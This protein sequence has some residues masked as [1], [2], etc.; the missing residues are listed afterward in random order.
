MRR[1]F[2]AMMLIC[3]AAPA[4][5]LSGDESAALTK[6]E[7]YLNGI[8]TLQARFVQVN[9][10]GTSYEGDLFLSRPGKMR[11][12]YDPPT[13]M[14]L[15]AD[16]VFLISVDTQMKDATRIDLNDTPAGLLLKENLSFSDP[17]V[18]LRGV[19]MGANTIEITAAMAKDPTA[20]Q[21]TMV[22][23][24]SPLELKQWRVVDAQRK[25]VIVTLQDAK[26]GV[27]LDPT[28]FKYDARK[29]A[30]TKN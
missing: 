1:L 21:L 6:A 8:A 12:T 26:T 14:L 27:K 20:G 28:L 17:S 9:P 25:E 3:A 18:K 29:D 15:V 23:T 7:K 13:P 19:K 10:N 5:A 2:L 11:L 16:G 24:Q 30:R 22:F 4:F